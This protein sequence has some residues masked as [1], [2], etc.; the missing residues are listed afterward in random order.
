MDV[1]KA[2]EDRVAKEQAEKDQHVEAEEKVA[3]EQQ[4][5]LAKLA[6]INKEVSP[7]IL[8]FSFVT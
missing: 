2:S 3:R 1:R 5:Q 6:Q 8:E 7:S 4:E